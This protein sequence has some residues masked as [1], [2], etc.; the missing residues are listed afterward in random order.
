[1]KLEALRK[2]RKNM[3]DFRYS[4]RRDNQDHSQQAKALANQQAEN[5]GHWMQVKSCA[6]YSRRDQVSLRWSATRDL[7]AGDMPPS[8]AP[9][10]R[11]S[12]R[13]Q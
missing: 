8:S 5:D 13:E 1:M 2:P 3:K 10:E 7:H 12:C 11:E 6:K 9:S 4:N